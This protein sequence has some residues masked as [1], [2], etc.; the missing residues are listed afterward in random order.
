MVNF[1]QSIGRHF[2]QEQL[3]NNLSSQS[4]SLGG[5]NIMANCQIPSYRAKGVC[6]FRFF[7]IVENTPK[8]EKRFWPLLKFGEELGFELGII[9]CPRDRAT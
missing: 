9:G 1:D 2:S 4:S 5:G 3:I 8:I 7:K 6:K